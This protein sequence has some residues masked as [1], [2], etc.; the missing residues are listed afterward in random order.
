MNNQEKIFW[1]LV[2]AIPVGIAIGIAGGD[3]EKASKPKTPAPAA[4]TAPIRQ[5]PVT[6]T[7]DG[8]N[9]DSVSY[10]YKGWQKANGTATYNAAEGFV[11]FP[12]YPRRLARCYQD[13]RLDL[14]GRPNDEWLNCEWSYTADPGYFYEVTKAGT[15]GKAPTLIAIN[16]VSI[17]SRG[18]SS[19]SHGK[20]ML[21][22]QGASGRWK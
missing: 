5:A 21:K 9:Y 18:S 8:T 7:F 12:L 6:P 13:G 20:A 19:D 17:S 2:V 1:G 22:P 16:K 4:K 11:E 15:H 3:T 14:D 10:L